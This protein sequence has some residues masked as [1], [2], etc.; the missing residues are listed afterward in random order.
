MK[1]ERRSFKTFLGDTLDYQESKQIAPEILDDMVTR[2]REGDRSMI[3][4]I[5]KGHYRMV[6]AMLAESSRSRAR[7]ADIEGAA[8]LSLV[9][10]VNDCCPHID[11]KGVFQP[12]RLY[13]NNI[14]YYITT[15]VKYAIKDEYG[16]N[17]VLR[18]SPRTIR[19]RIAKGEKFED[20]VP[21]A[22]MDI[23]DDMPDYDNGEGN[24]DS[25]VDRCKGRRGDF[26]MPF[27]VLQAKP[28]FPCV[29]FTEAIKKCVENET[30]RAIIRLRAEGYGYEDIGKKVG[31]STGRVGQIVPLIE[32][33]FDRYYP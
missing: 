26:V 22:G 20:I 23:L 29:E 17:H 14:T 6:T 27:I 13:D 33:R 12:S 2:L 8:F 1:P 9:E 11:K 24:D 28:E 18:M 25:F 3:N 7:A 31:Y 4:P 15:T 5:I 19:D 30:E 32:A 21:G 10:A 16:N